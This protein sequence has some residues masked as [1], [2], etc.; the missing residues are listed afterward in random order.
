MAVAP[1]A[2]SVHDVEE[3]A[4]RI[5]GKLRETPL[6]PSGELSRR[7]GARVLLK[8]ENLQLTGSFKARGATNMIAQLPDPAL[9]AGV[10]AASAGNHAQ[11]VAW[12]GRELGVAATVFM[13][14]DAAMAKIDATR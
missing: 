5:A 4:R 10:V 9:R 7:A 6:V 1:E 13:P 12:A 2:V 14:Q 8:A 11:A 3:A